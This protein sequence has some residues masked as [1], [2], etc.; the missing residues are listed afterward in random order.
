MVFCAMGTY[1]IVI[2]GAQLAAYA[3]NSEKEAYNTMSQSTFLVLIQVLSKPI[4]KKVTKYRTPHEI[5]CYLKQT[6]HVDSAFSFIH[7]MYAVCN[8][9]QT[10]STTQFINEF[11][12]K[13]ETEWERLHQL[14]G[15]AGS[16]HRR[17]LRQFLDYDESKRDFLLTALVQHYPNPID[18]LCTKDNLTYV[19]LKSRLFMLSNNNHHQLTTNQLKNDSALVTRTAKR[20]NKS[21][22]YTAP[23][24]ETDTKWCTY[25]KKHGMNYKGHTWQICRR[26][27]RV[28]EKKTIPDTNNAAAL[29]TQAQAHPVVSPSSLYTWKFDTCASS[30]MTSD[31]GKF[32]TLEPYHGTVTIGGDTL[33]QAEGIG[34][35]IIYCL[36]PDNTVNSVHLTD[37]LYVPTLNH[38]LFS[39]NSFRSKG[40]RWEA[41]V[42]HIYLYHNTS[43]VLMTEFHG[44]LPYIIEVRHH[45]LISFPKSYM[46]WHA[47]L[48]HPSKLSETSYL[49]GDLIPKI[50]SD[51]ECSTCIQAKSTYSIPPP[52]PLRSTRPFEIIHS[53]LSGISPVLS[54]GN[55]R[56]YITFI[57][58]FSRIAW[59]YFLKQKLEAVTTIQIFIAMAERQFNTKILCFKTDHGGEYIN[60]TLIQ[61]FNQHGI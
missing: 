12:D 16:P 59:V 22:S 23:A 27:K 54:Y 32:C 60:N 28:Q 21:A 42:S 13:F 33:L 41:G 52:H 34:T 55:S 6:Y 15:S 39:W 49:D 45:A 4:L 1:S 9:S 61:L 51:F 37:V 11:V 20:S 57:D 56:Y 30:H 26:L 31:I 53:D 5:W 50:P 58:D 35:V 29:I 25:C 24:K 14:T 3:L 38:N 43:L 7:Q 46:Y 19:E 48:G 10:F 47:S 44:N 8:M 36:L 18:N 2:D 17:S 40:Y